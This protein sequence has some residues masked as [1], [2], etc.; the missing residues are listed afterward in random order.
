MPPT[1]GQV[2]A[3]LV[4][5][6]GVY[7]CSMVHARVAEWPM[8]GAWHACCQGAQS[9]AQVNWSSVPFSNTLAAKVINILAEEPA[10]VAAW[11]VPRMRCVARGQARAMQLVHAVAL[12]RPRRCCGGWAVKLLHC[13]AVHAAPALHGCPGNLAPT[14]CPTCPTSLCRG[15]TGQGAYIK[16]LTPAG[17]AW[18]FLTARR[19]RGR[20]VPEGTAG[21]Q[22]LPS[23]GSGSS[24]PAAASR[25]EQDGP[26]I[27][28]SSQS[29]LPLP[30]HST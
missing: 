16:F 4:V 30:N 7:Q 24:A 28:S 9:G 6:C 15:V 17:A 11:L 5:M 19:R 26:L 27:H 3:L 14:V 25:S 12:M 13:R 8:A 18:R 1:H 20:F 21:Y 10:A 23:G 29:H 22:Q 2:S